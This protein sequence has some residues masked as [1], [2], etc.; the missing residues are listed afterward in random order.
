MWNYLGVKTYACLYAFKYFMLL[1]LNNV[2]CKVFLFINI[3]FGFLFYGVKGG[4]RQGYSF[5]LFS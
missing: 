2:A 5:L 4:A 3:T 1:C